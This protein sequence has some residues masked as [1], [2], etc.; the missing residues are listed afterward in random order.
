MTRIVL[1]GGRVFDGTGAD[2][3]DG[4][5]ALEDGRFVD[6]GTGLDGDQAVDVTGKTILPGLF[7]CHTHVC[8]S[9]V[10]LWGMVQEPFSIQFYEAQAN[11]RRTLEIGITDARSSAR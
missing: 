10:D 11:L 2:P 4:D 1:Q 5:V 6:V 8:F 9:N 3:A 7:D